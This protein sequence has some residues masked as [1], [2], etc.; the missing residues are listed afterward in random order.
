VTLLVSLNVVFTR[1]KVCFLCFKWATVF[2]R[3]KKTL[4]FKDLRNNHSNC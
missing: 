2:G 3:N 4:K 1:V